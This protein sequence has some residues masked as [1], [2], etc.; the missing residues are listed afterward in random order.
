M[1]RDLEKAGAAVDDLLVFVA[2]ER[3][4]EVASASC[5]AVATGADRSDDYDWASEQQV[6]ALCL[7]C[8]HGV[9]GG[10][11]FA[12]G[13]RRPTPGAGRVFYCAFHP[14]VPDVQGGTL[15]S[16]Q[17]HALDV[18]VGENL[19]SLADTYAVDDQQ[20]YLGPPE[21]LPLAARQLAA[22]V[23]RQLY[24]PVSGLAVEDHEIGVVIELVQAE[25]AAHMS[26]KVTERF[27]G[28]LVGGVQDERRQQTA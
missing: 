28:Q 11:R 19:P 3:I 23:Q 14:G 1:E 9:A 26:V 6:L 20:R 25:L 15:V 16:G 8:R 24:R 2:L 27:T 4:K 12:A 7:C 18:Q 5:F 22:G 17:L 13:G 21:L 10:P